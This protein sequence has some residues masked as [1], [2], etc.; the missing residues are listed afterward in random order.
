MT[1]NIQAKDPG[2]PVFFFHRRDQVRNEKDESYIGLQ[3]SW[4]PRE[5]RE[6]K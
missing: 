6:S 2:A 3:I 4:I 5:R 1:E